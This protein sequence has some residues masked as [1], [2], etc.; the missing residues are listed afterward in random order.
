MPNDC[1]NVIYSIEHDNPDVMIRLKNSL[2]QDPPVFFAE[3]LPCPEN[4]HP[5]SYWGTK[6]DVY[7]VYMLEDNDDVLQISFYTAWSP[8]LAAYALLKTLGFTIEANFMEYGA[9]FCGYWKDGIET[10]Y[11]N[12]HDNLHNVPEEFHYYFLND[13]DDE[14]DDED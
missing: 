4:E 12:V 9:D 14:D 13:Q 7:D 1:Y 8:P 6:W 3:F 5:T 2:K 11:E 10:I